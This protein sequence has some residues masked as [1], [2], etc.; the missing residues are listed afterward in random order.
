[1]KN[2]IIIVLA[3]IALLV[4]VILNGSSIL[5]LLEYLFNGASENCIPIFIAI[6]IVWVIR[7][8]VKAIQEENQI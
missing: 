1:M 2:K 6:G 8:R 3:S 4:L 7:N 5:S